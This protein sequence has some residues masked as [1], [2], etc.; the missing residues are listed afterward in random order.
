MD[1]VNSI[2]KRLWNNLIN[3]LEHITNVHKYVEE[4]IKII[5]VKL[6]RSSSSFKEL[7]KQ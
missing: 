4:N 6:E 5:I 2:K 3:V 7:A 1:I